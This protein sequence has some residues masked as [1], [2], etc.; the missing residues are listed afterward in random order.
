MQALAAYPRVRLAGDGSKQQ[1]LRHPQQRLAASEPR[2]GPALPSY[3]ALHHAGF[4]G[5]RYHYRDGGLLP[6][7]FTLAC[8][9]APSHSPAVGRF[10][11]QTVTEAVDGLRT[12]GLVSVALSVAKRFAG[13]VQAPP[14]TVRPPGVTRRVALVRSAG[15]GIDCGLRAAANLVSGLSSLPINRDSDRPAHPPATF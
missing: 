9:V 6:H 12:G 5:S 7:R 14:A 10:P 2:A 1:R 13:R 4:S 15:E 11:F 8:T 3:L